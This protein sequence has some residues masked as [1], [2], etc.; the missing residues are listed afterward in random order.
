MVM[1]LQKFYP[2]VNVDVVE[3]DRDV[4]KVALEYFG[5]KPAP[6]TEIYIMDARVYL[7]RAEKKYDL[8][9]LDAYNDSSIPFHLTTIEF[10]KLVRDHLKP[11]GYAVGNIWSPQSNRF[12]DAEIKTYQATFD[13]LYILH[14][15]D[16]GNYL[17]V[18]ATQKGRRT[19]AQV[20]ERAQKVAG[21][22]KLNFDL[23]ALARRTY[24]YDTDR[25]VEA[26]ILTDDRAP[27]NVLRSRR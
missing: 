18:G 14:A 25:A 7:R 17:F 13:E 22:R 21:Q 5:L 26:R 1:W 9:F 2:E 27:V 12:F 10:M 16:S 20:G 3:V 4:Q 24:S 6:K 11:G 8:I 15:P 23:P 19:A